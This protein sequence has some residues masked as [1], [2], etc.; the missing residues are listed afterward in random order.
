LM[1]YLLLIKSE[2]KR[3]KQPGVF[4]QGRHTIL[5]V[6]GQDILAIRCISKL[7]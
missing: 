5:A 1:L 2:K 7:L 6:P 4:S 3:E